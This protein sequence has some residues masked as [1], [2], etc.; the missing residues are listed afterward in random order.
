MS[1]TKSCSTPRSGRAT[2]RPRTQHTVSDMSSPLPPGGDGACPA[3]SPGQRS[4]QTDA[5][6]VAVPALLTWALCFFRLGVSQ[7][8]RDEESTWW[9]ARLPWEDFVR[10]LGNL[11]AVLAPYYLFMRG[12]VGLFGDSESALRAPS[13]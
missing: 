9:A 13:A 8:W 7:L 6:T 1:T 10:L 12:W 4:L 11:D 2:S 5:T 3:P